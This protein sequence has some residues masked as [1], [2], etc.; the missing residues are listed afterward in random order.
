[1]NQRM[2]I[3]PTVILRKCFFTV[4]LFCALSATATAQR[5]STD[6][7]RHSASEAN[8]H[9]GPTAPDQASTQN[10][11]A[12]ADSVSGDE[13]LGMSAENH[14]GHGMI[15]T[16]PSISPDEAEYEPY[17]LMKMGGGSFGMMLVDQFEYRMQDGDDLWRWDAEGWYGGDFN[18]FWF[19]T[20]G[21]LKVQGR[22]NGGGEIH[23]YYSRLVAPFWD[24]QV[25]IRYDEVWESG[26]NSSRFFGAIGLEGFAP[27]RFEVQ[28]ALFIS[29]NGDVSARFTATRDIRITQRLIAQPRFETEISVQDVPKFDV[30]SGFN[31]VELGFRVRYE[32]RREFAPYIG[33]NWETELGN[34]AD[35]TRRGGGDVDVLAVVL[36]AQLWF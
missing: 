19:K 12:S 11:P 34:T 7:P 28:P 23:G 25:G 9:S 27:Y 22:S 17:N 36:G 8:A 2:T 20:E 26:G 15:M 3:E 24:A 18:R 13:M 29:E 10:I 31:Y 32:I 4:V 6:D 14:S 1:M 16:Q 5:E 35:I 33:V 30:G 21:E